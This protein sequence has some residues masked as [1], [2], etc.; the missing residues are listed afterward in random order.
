MPPLIRIS[1]QF[2]ELMDKM[3]ASTQGFG[4]LKLISHENQS[5]Y[6]KKKMQYNPVYP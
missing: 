3:K 4:E 1:K 5:S 2:I 6:E